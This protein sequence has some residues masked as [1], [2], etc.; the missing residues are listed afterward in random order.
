MQIQHSYLIRCIPIFYLPEPTIYHFNASDVALKFAQRIHYR[1][2]RQVI[3]MTESP[4]SVIIFWRSRQI[5]N[6]RQSCRPRDFILRK[7]PKPVIMPKVLHRTINYSW[8]YISRV[9]SASNWFFLVLFITRF[10]VL[11]KKIFE[12]ALIKRRAQKKDHK[13][14]KQECFISCLFVAP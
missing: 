5:S 4:E 2:L 1:Q 9:C 10:C 14:R 6:T 13:K 8:S 7:V 3:V 11:R 12:E